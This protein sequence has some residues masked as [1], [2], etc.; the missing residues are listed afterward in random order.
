MKTA[1][2]ILPLLFVAACAT[3]GETPKG[4]HIG[5]ALQPR[6]IHPLAEV[7]AAPQDYAKQTLWVEATVQA[8]CQSKGCWMQVA[9]GD[10]TAMVRWETGC[11]GKFAFPKDAAGER[12][13]IQGSYYEKE[14]AKA[15]AEHIESEAGGTIEVPEHGYELNASA[16]VLLDRQAE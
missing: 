14:I 12:V 5:D 3:Q 8:V 16:V 7:Q 6:P 13:L 1:L 9:D 11:G 10:E 15:D 4:L 2:S